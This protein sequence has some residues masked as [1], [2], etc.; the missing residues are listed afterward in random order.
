MY[1]KL[2]DVAQVET[3]KFL[4]KTEKEKHGLM[5]LHGRHPVKKENNDSCGVSQ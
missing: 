5:I 3:A 2:W 1:L 4:E